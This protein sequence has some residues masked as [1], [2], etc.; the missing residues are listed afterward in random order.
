[1]YMTAKKFKLLAAALIYALSFSFFSTGAALADTRPY[2]RA[3]GADVFAGGWFENNSVSCNPGVS[4]FQAP[5]YSGNTDFYKG[6][7]M[8]Y[9]ISS[10]GTTHGAGSEF[11]ALSLGIIEGQNSGEPYGF[12]TGSS[13]YN[14]LSFANKTS[15]TASNYWGGFLEGTNRQTHCIPD[16]FNTFKKSATTLVSAA[17]VSGLNSDK[18]LITGATTIG[19]TGSLAA[20][21]RITIF[22][23]GNAY[24]SS[25]ITYGPH[26]ESNV[27]KFA[28]VVKGSIYI[29]PGVSQLDGLYIAQPD[30]TLANPVTADSGDIWTCHGPTA[31]PLPDAAYIYANCRTTGANKGR[32]VFNGAVIAKQINLFRLDGDVATAAANEASNSTNIAEVFNFTPEMVVGGGFFNIPAGSGGKL[33][34]LISLPPVF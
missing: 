22:V 16:Y 21:K 11:G 14:A 32:L 27:Q 2:F 17:D 18:Y 23:D 28:L 12:G 4:T 30:L 8:A 20:N 31:L 15:L 24:I 3:Y 1:M 19:S 10:G 34:S 13:G 9:G 25:N 29:A 7:I 33:D 6:A 26:V 5:N